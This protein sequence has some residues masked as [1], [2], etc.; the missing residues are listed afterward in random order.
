[1]VQRIYEF[2]TWQPGYG[3]ASVSVFVAGTTTLATLYTSEAMSTTADNPQTLSSKAAPDGTNYGKFEAPIYCN[4]SYYL[5]IDGIEQTGII[6]PPFTSLNG[7][8]A[9]KETVKAAG[10]NYGVELED[11]VAQVVNAANY[12]SFV[13]GAGGVAATNT[14]T[15]Q[16]AIAALVSG[17]EVIVPSGTYNINSFDVPEGVIIRGQGREATT[18]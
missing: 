18:L 6:R 3:G 9:S 8:D 17:G 10:S 7:E 14:A 11:I 1:M 12:G 16:L 15:I 2:D 5:D 13:S 4:Q